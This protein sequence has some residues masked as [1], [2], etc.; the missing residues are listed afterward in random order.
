MINNGQAKEL[1]D[2]IEAFGDRERI[3]G[4]ELQKNTQS[5]SAFSVVAERSYSVN[6]ALNEVKRLLQPHLDDPTGPHGLFDV[7][8]RGSEERFE[9]DFGPDD[10]AALYD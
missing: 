8:E 5:E 2:A 3:Y 7:P 6:R 1:L 9:P 4:R 10:E